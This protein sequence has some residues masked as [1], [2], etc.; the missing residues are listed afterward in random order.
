MLSIAVLPYL[1]LATV[2]GGL[3]S[4]QS[5]GRSASRGSPPTL[6]KWR[7]KCV[8]DRDC[9]RYALDDHADKVRGMDLDGCK[10]LCGSHGALFPRPA[11]S[12][13]G[14]NLSDFHINKVMGAHNN[15]IIPCDSYYAHIAFQNSFAIPVEYE[16]IPRLSDLLIR[17]RESFKSKLYVM[18]SVSPVVESGAKPSGKPLIVVPKIAHADNLK[19]DIET[20]ESYSLSV[21]SDQR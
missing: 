20:D 1:L 4:T 3:A 16:N 12:K 17:G 21:T 14:N 10:S 8:L 11:E 19:L 2:G 6:A 5:S 9:V 15:I 18:G 13:L 7:W